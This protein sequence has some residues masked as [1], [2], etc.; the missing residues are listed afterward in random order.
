MTPVKSNVTVVIPHYWDVRNA[1]LRLIIG[2]LNSGTVVPDTILIWN[3]GITL[4]E[5]FP[6]NVKVINWPWNL[7]CK[8]R[9]VAALCAETDYILFQD[10]D[11]QVRPGTLEHMLDWYDVAH[12][13]LTAFEG[14]KL[15]Q[16]QPYEKCQFVDGAGLSNEVSV[17]ISIGRLELTRHTVVERCLKWFPFQPDTVMDDIWFSFAAKMEQIPR[18]VIPYKQDNGYVNLDQGGVGAYRAPTH[19]PH[20]DELCR[21][22]FPRERNPA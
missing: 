7:G 14:R 4:N 16:G 20:R 1:N 22:L 11:V 21:K 18:L 15:I 2:A 6:A 8:A 17:D 13:S 3:N 10:N 19:M 12:D 5:V 9:L